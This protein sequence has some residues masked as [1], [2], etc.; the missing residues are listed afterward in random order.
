MDP[1]TMSLILG[2]LGA[3][4]SVGGSLLGGNQK[5]TRTQKQ[6]RELVDDLIASLKG[7]GSFNDLFQMDEA[8]FQKSFVDPA[9][10]RFSNQTAPQIQQSFISGGQQRGTGLDDTLTRAGVDMDQLLNEQYGNFQN[11]ALNRQQSAIGQILG[12]DPGVQDPLSTGEKLGQGVSGFV[13]GDAFSELLKNFSQDN[14]DR[15]RFKES[16]RVGQAE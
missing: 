3:V 9:K 6:K 14:R 11:A 4:G 13:A 8:A 5:E 15:D 12:A 10:A 1:A 2:G 7:N 16:T